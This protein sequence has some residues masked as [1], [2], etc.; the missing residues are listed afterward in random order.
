MAN[1]NFDTLQSLGKGVKVIHGSFAPNGAS[2]VSAASNK[3]IGF[4]VV[5]TSAGVFT[6]TLQDSFVGLLSASLV[7][8]LSAPDDKFV[9]FGAIDVVTAKTLV[10]N[11]WDVSAASVTDIAAN[12]ANRI[13]FVLY[14]S[15]ST[16]V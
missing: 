15:N 6:V 8:Q 3:G 9:Q 16:A 5:R 2:A 1:R 12:A 10:I 4:S 13:D 7:L 11:V 14:L